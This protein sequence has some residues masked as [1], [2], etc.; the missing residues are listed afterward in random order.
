MKC[1][2]TL[3]CYLPVNQLVCMWGKGCSVITLHYF[4]HRGLSCWGETEKVLQ[5]VLHSSSVAHLRSPSGG[6]QKSW[7]AKHDLF[8]AIHHMLWDSSGSSSLRLPVKVLQHTWTFVYACPCICYTLS[9][10]LL[11]LL[12]KWRHVLSEV[13]NV[14][15]SLSVSKLLACS[16][17]S[18]ILINAW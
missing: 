6:R 18:R 15:V 14:K 12:A 11:I 10:K 1:L 5:T 4:Q 9:T 13:K 17:S 8:T 7:E 16:G 2:P 3:F